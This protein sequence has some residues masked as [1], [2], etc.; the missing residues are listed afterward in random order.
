MIKNICK[1]HNYF[2]EKSIKMDIE[3]KIKETIN[4]DKIYKEISF[5]NDID[6]ELSDFYIIDNRTGDL[7]FIYGDRES[8]LNYKGYFIDRPDECIN[9]SNQSKLLMETR[10]RNPYFLG[11]NVYSSMFISEYNFNSD[12]IIHLKLN[13]GV[14]SNPKFNYFYLCI[15][16]LESIKIV[17]PFVKPHPISNL[18]VKAV[19]FQYERN[20]MRCYIADQ[21][22]NTY[23]AVNKKICN[24]IENSYIIDFRRSMVHINGNVLNLNSIH[25]FK[26]LKYFLLCYYTEQKLPNK[27]ELKRQNIVIGKRKGFL[28]FKPFI[29]PSNINLEVKIFYKGN[30]EMEF[31]SYKIN[32]WIPVKF[33]SISINENNKVHIR[34]KLNSTDK[35]MKI[36]FIEK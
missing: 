25:F 28:Y 13:N 29:V 21:D 7:E 30:I 1:S 26:A 31:Y 12:D 20:Y 27:F 10:I 2:V 33:N 32:K 4:N 19:G 9:V 17:N 3:E 15:G 34:I 8:L 24:T 35:I 14:F 23:F 18:H 22:S 5:E 11:E 16:N 6:K 36:F